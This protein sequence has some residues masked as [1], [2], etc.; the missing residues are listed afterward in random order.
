[1]AT[2]MT[3]SVIWITGLSGAGKSTLAEQVVFELKQ[4]DLH[5]ILLDGDCLREITGTTNTKSQDFSKARRLALSMSYCKLCKLL[6]DQGFLV[7]IATI[8]M[9][10][11]IHAWNR[12]NLPKYFEVYVKASL[13]TLRQRDPKGIYRDF[14]SQ[15]IHNVAGLDLPVD[16]P[17]APDFFANAEEST[18]RDTVKKLIDAMFERNFL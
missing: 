15:L 18:A 3:G 13:D 8:S 17:E 11:E 14:D 5:A 6:S 12:E 4:L 7:V 9:F 1:M 10:S 16:E 2:N